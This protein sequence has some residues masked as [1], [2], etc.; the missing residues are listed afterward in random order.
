[1]AV[2][3]LRPCVNGLAVGKVWLARRLCV[4]M[5]PKS[6]GGVVMAQ[7]VFVGVRPRKLPVWILEE[8]PW[9]KELRE[10]LVEYVS[11]ALF[12]TAYGIQQV[13]AVLQELRELMLMDGVDNWLVG[14][15]MEQIRRWVELAK[16]GEEFD[17]IDLLRTFREYVERVSEGWEEEKGGV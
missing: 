8:E 12:P 9:R 5:F 11:L 3:P 2:R 7:A 6:F 14:E 1:M 16:K 4:I 13:V 17:L 10:L 15:A